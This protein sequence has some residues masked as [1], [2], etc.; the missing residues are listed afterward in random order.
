M[1]FFRVWSV[2]QAFPDLGFQHRGVFCKAEL[3]G[4][5]GELI[6]L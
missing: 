5:V 3:F 6:G 1:T 4:H 2:R